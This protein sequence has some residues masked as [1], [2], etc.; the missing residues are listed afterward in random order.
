MLMLALHHIIYNLLKFNAFFGLFNIFKFTFQEKK[1]E[2][3][4]GGFF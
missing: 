2:N 3:S 4:V 1:E